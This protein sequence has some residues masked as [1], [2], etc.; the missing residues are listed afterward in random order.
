MADAET[1]LPPLPSL[2]LAARAPEP[3][4]LLAP[5]PEPVVVAPAPRVEQVINF[6]FCYK[7]ALAFSSTFVSFRLPIADFHMTSLKFKLQNY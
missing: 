3:T 1:A 5:T 2:N 6:L 4:P 7:S